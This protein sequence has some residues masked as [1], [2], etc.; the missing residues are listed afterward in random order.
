MNRKNNVFRICCII[1][2][3][4]GLVPQVFLIV[5]ILAIHLFLRL[6]IKLVYLSQTLTICY[7]S[8]W[9]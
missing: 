3:E 2:H 6:Q 4:I 7:A 1:D 8:I 5:G 9:Y